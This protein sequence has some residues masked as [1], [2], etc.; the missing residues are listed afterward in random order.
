M[1]EY[2]PAVVFS[3]YD[4]YYIYSPFTNVLTEVG[5]DVTVD[6]EYKDNNILDGLKPYISYTCK[7]SYNGK[8]YLITYSLDNYILVDVYD[9]G[10]KKET[11]AGYL[12][13]GI[14]KNSSTQYEYDGVTVNETDYEQ[15]HEY[16]GDGREYYYADI[17][18]TKYYYSGTATSYN[19]TS[20]DD[21]IFYINNSGE[22][23]KQVN[24]KENNEP[25]F[26]YYYKMI[27]EN[28]SA[29]CYYRDA[30][31]FTQW[32]TTSEDITF[33]NGD[34]SNGQDLGGL[35]VSDIKEID[36]YEN[37]NF[38]DVGNI[39]DTTGTEHFEDSDSKFNQHRKDV[40]RAVISTNLSTAIT[41]FGK[42]SKSNDVEFIMP[43]ISEDDWELLENNVCIATFFQGM[44]IGGKTYNKYSVVPNNLNKEYVDENDI[45]FLTS[46]HTYSRVNDKSYVGTT[47][48]LADKDEL[49][50]FPAL[51]KI[52]F[53]VRKN[54]NGGY[55]N[56]ISYK[57]SGSY[58]PYLGEY[59]SI[60][61]SSNVA[62][63][64][65]GDMYKYMRGKLKDYK[66]R[67]YSC[68]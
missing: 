48:N 9:S 11:R 64:S 20:D 42:Y 46:S 18:G 43:K 33:A 4:G 55:Y 32:V 44:K 12:I 56:P 34:E 1:K 39:F 41:G 53:E 52:K 59:T 2:V 51:S 68:W 21:Y 5:S 30:Y 29:Y 37:Y 27:F 17:N 60:S 62:S 54:T 10:G 61:G 8:T 25:K 6:A 31:I 67:L 26:E 50:Y 63:V 23:V 22:R 40:I 49:Y 65:T 36:N 16:L 47:I 7:Y 66:R 14:K 35:K 19:S 57:E 13:S 45:Y 15:L 24:S 58:A 28:N 38:Y 3:L